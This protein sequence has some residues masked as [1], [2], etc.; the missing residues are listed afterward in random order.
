MAV[1]SVVVHHVEGH[2]SGLDGPPSGS[3]R[4]AGGDKVS[5]LGEVSSA[6]DS[7][8]SGVDGFVLTPR[9]SGISTDVLL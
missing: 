4:C 1:P 6:V 2:A 8:M 7:H 9:H 3:P 5:Q